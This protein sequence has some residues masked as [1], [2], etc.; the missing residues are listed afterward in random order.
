MKRNIKLLLIFL[1]CMC[2]VS[3]SCYVRA[4]DE[5]DEDICKITLTADKTTVKPGDEVTITIKM[6]NITNEAGVTRFISELTTPSG[7]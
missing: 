2:L 3:F 7:I 1:I 5:E 6:S 4:E